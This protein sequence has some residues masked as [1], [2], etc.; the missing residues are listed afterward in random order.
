[1]ILKQIG[2]NLLRLL[3]SEVLPK[4]HQKLGCLKAT[5]IKKI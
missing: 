2:L 4:L 1:M 3:K 5:R